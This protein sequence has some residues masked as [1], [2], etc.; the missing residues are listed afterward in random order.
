MSYPR[1]IR[2]AL[3]GACL[4]AAG[5]VLADDVPDL[6]KTPGVARPGLTEAQICATKWGKD[7][8][9]N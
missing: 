6:S 1:F 2:F 9:R 3:T 4:I 5:W 8:M 7:A